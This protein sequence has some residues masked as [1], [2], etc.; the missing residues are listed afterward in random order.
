MFKTHEGNREQWY[1][2]K[3]HLIMISF[4]FQ[5]L[6]NLSMFSHS[7]CEEDIPFWSHQILRLYKLS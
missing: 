2:I 4:F 6:D 5:K 3:L 7:Q 1:H